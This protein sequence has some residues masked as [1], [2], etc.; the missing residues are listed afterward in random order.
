MGWCLEVC[1]TFDIDIDI[2]ID[3]HF[4]YVTD[5]DVYLLQIKLD[6]WK[7]DHIKT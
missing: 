2:D 7:P 1:R 5:S 3:C 6:C 4:A